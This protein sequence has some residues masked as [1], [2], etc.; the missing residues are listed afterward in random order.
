M[1]RRINV[2][3]I[4]DNL[5]KEADQ[6]IYDKRI[7]RILQSYGDVFY[8]G[9]Y[10]LNTM[11]WPDIDITMTL[12]SDPYSIEIFFEIGREIARIDDIISLKFRNSYRL[13][14][15]GL[16]RG[17]YWGIR[18]DVGDWDMPWKIDLWARDKEALAEDRATMERVHQAMDEETRRLIIETKRSLLTPEGRTPPLSGFHIY[19]AVLFKGLRKE[20]DIVAYLKKQGIQQI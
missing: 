16:P 12:K 19:E 13:P 10:F 2:L 1:V 9:S 20:E 14:G 3:D 5:R 4:A 8:T 6:I 18:L 11:A 17:L 7:N 15:Q